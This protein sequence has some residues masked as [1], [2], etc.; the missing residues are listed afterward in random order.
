MPK[1]NDISSILIIG[2]GPIII[3]QACEFDYSGTQACQ[4]L[5]EEGYKVILIN[6]N[7]ATIMTDHNIADVT[8]IEP[9]SEEFIKKI[10]DKENID[11]ILPTMG[12]QIALNCGYNLAQDK[13]IKQKNIKIIGCN[14]KSIE[15]SEDRQ[16]FK[17]AMQNVDIDCLASFIAFSLTEAL[18]KIEN[19]EINFPV[20]IRPAFTLS[21]YGG[22]I[23]HNI[24]EFKTICNNGINASP[25]NE[26]L[27]EES[28]IGWKEFEIEI[29]KD[30]EDNVI[31]V[32][33]IENIDPMGVHTGDSITVSPPLTLS[34]TEY[35]KMRD[36]SIKA[37]RAIELEAGCANVQFAV[38]PQNGRMIIIEINPRVSRSSAL[39]SKITGFPIAKIAAKLS[40]G[41][42]LA[43]LRNSITDNVIPASFEP[44]LDY[45]AIKIPKFN[46]EKFPHCS[47]ELNTSMKSI[48]EIVSLGGSFQEALQK[49]IQSVYDQLYG[50]NL[51]KEELSLNKIKDLLSE[52]KP[53]IILYIAEALRKNMPQEEI[54]K[55]CKYDKWFVEQIA[56]IISAE[57]IIKTHGLGDKN[58]L[59]KIK[60]LG[61]SDKYLAVLTGMQYEE[62]AQKRYDLSV[63][64]VYKRIDSCAAEFDTTTFCLYSCYMSLD[65]QSECESLPSSNKK[66]IVIGSGANSIGQGVEFD[67]CCVN[68]ITT[69]KQNDYEA[70]IINCNPETVSTDYNISDKLYIE[71]LN[72]EHIINIIKTEQKNGE[73]VGVITQFGGQT[74][75]T[76]HK[77]L[78]K[79]NIPVLGTDFTS[80][81]IAENRNLFSQ[82]LIKNDLL[83]QNSA[84]ATNLKELNSKIDAINYP[85][86]LRP[87]FVIGGRAMAII[88]SDKD[89]EYFL[90]NNKDISEQISKDNPIIVEQY[91]EDGLELD[92]EIIRDQYGNTVICAI[93]EH[94]ERAGIHSGDSACFMPVQSL[95]KNVLNNIKQ[96][97]KII[98]NKLNIVGLLNVQLVIKHNKIYIIE[99]NP[100]ASR[101]IPFISK[102]TGQPVVQIAT[103]ATLGSN[104]NKMQINDNNFAIEHIAVKESVMPF[105][106]LNNTSISLG[107][108]MKST[109]ESMGIDY[110]LYDAFAKS[111]ISAKN[112]MQNNSLLI[113]AE[114]P[115]QHIIK[116]IEEIFR[117]ITTTKAFKVF[118]NEN[119]SNLITE[120]NKEFIN[121]IKNNDIT[122]FITDNDVGLCLY[123]NYSYLISNGSIITDLIVKHSIPYC[124]TIESTMLMLNSFLHFNKE[125]CSVNH[126][127]EFVKYSGK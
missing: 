29:V 48:G 34:D 110:N 1:R 5:R 7:P 12:G 59:L 15:I 93:L 56:E 26:I 16:E 42:N 40:I 30:K 21:G 74:A 96:Q 84:I 68:A 114:K 47:T 113:L 98:A 104:L 14:Q 53:M 57:K 81:E 44:S 61:F 87:S 95:H 111:Q 60:Q 51:Y 8:Y 41:Y 39:A 126:L 11:A 49:G 10:I 32:C 64:P 54:I 6:S 36:T 13:Y 2:S 124:T 76:M 28:A 119:V 66:I 38:N 3:G 22:G 102:A 52:T 23:A 72:E 112:F 20:I 91:I 99:A 85:I 78:Y 63:T 46:F 125:Q 123:I 121:I 90:I 73:L 120:N 82:L 80:V 71:P 69:V 107:P 103:L 118:A 50:F 67:Y 25:V 117:I 77:I 89:K 106:R 18:N 24:E 19:S 70:I 45:I 58:N 31:I 62:I 27:I 92:V 35:Q 88:N 86:I 79:H 127:N 108:E 115:D 94:I 65:D 55:Y 9:I 116:N 100:R 37:I 105:N 4:G 122:K 97:T 33:A 109:G 83:Q 75:L 17:K 43:E 101:T